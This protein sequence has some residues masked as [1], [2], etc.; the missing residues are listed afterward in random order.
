MIIEKFDLFRIIWT[1]ILSILLIIADMICPLK[2]VNWVLF[3]FF[4]RG[5][6]DVIIQ[7]IKEYINEYTK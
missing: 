3:I 1:I 7:L 5:V 4:M 2:Y 6:I